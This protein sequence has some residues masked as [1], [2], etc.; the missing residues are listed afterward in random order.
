MITVKPLSFEPQKFSLKIDPEVFVVIKPATFADEGTR[1]AMLFA[2]RKS[3][4]MTEVASVELWLT[5]VECNILN[6][7]TG[8]PILK[9]GLT[10][11]EFAAGLSAIWAFDPDIV[12]DMHE[13]SR[14]VNP[15]WNPEGN[16]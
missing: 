14:Q 6:A 3:A 9:A 2:D 13:K 4:P 15:R 5:F 8:E 16:A 12:W 10:Y 11:E 7:E 1:F